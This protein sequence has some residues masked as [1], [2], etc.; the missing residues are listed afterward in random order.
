MNE[1]NTAQ[2]CVDDPIQ[3]D[4]QIVSNA[5]SIDQWLMM[6]DDLLNVLLW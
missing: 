1:A 2:R 4:D 6:E 3:D 5:V